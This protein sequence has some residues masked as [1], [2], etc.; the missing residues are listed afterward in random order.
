V[1][2]KIERIKSTNFESVAAHD[3]LA[4]LPLRLRLLLMARRIGSAV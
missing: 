2:G 1:E 3:A 4:S